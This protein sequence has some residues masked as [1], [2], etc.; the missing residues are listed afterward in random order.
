MN[1]EA[2]CQRLAEEVARAHSEGR[3]ELRPWLEDL[4]MGDGSDGSDS[5]LNPDSLRAFAEKLIYIARRIERTTNAFQGAKR[6][7]EVNG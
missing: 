1:V 3:I 2:L 6:A 5:P 7:S 4:L